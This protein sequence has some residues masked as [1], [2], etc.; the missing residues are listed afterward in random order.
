MEVRPSKRFRICPAHF[1]GSAFHGKLLYVRR[2]CG[3]KGLCYSVDVELAMALHCSVDTSLVSTA[4]LTAMPTVIH[5]DCDSYRDAKRH[6]YCL[7]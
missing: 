6:V 4:M 1:G 5:A 2:S 3:G 7:L